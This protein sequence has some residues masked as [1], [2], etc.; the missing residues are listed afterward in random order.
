MRTFRQCLESA[1]HQTSPCREIIVIDRFSQD[2][3]LQFANSNGATVFQ[4]NTNRSEARNIGLQN[5]SSEGV[6]FVDADMILPPTLIEECEQGLKKHDAIVIPEESVGIGF[7]AE[8]R[9]AERRLHIGNNSIEAPRCFRRRALLSLG[10][11]NPQL[12]A[13]E[14][15]DLLNR[16]K[17]KGHSIGRVR[18]RI[19]H[20]EGRLTLPR[21]LEREFFY[22]QTFGK[23][24][25]TNPHTAFRQVNP[26]KRIVIPGVTVASRDGL[27][28]IGILILRSLEFAAAGVGHIVGRREPE[29]DWRGSK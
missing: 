3:I 26:V 10:G 22:G 28:G 27:H 29:V 25:A 9:A 2:G 5:V 20:D 18:A 6:L 1:K 11:Y 8:C 12:E 13:G 21:I 7:W 14:D 16:A 24:I 19:I 4:S 23:Y 15:W 17:S